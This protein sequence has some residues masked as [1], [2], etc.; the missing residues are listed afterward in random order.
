VVLALERPES[1]GWTTVAFDHITVSARSG[2]RLAIACLTPRSEGKRA[3]VVPTPSPK[4]PDPCADLHG[5]AYAGVNGVYPPQSIYDDWDFTTSPWTINFDAV[6]AG[7]V[8]SLEA[9]AVFGGAAA[10]GARVGVMVAH[11]QVAAD[12]SFPTVNLSFALPPTGAFW[13]TPPDHCDQGEDLSSWMNPSTFKNQPANPKACPRGEPALAYTPALARIATPSDVVGR[14]PPIVTSG[15]TGGEPDGVIVWKSDPIATEAP[16]TSL[17]LTGRFAQCASGDLR[18]PA[19]CP[20]SV[21]CTPPPT[22]LVVLSGARVVRSQRI[23]CVPSYPEAVQYMMSYSEVEPGP[24]AVG[25]RR[26][27]SE[28]GCFFDVYDFAVGG[29]Q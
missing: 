24:I 25:I 6:R 22:D 15:C 8:V 29:C 2:S 19:G 1:A 17:M 4:D 3:V 11:A 23:S 28:G 21:R 12:S 20:T 7:D 18:D 26:G 9:K 10:V 14:I 27:P 16:C 5:G 13:G